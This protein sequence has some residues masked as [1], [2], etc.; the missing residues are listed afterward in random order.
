VTDPRLGIPYRVRSRKY[1]SDRPE[2]RTRNSLIKSST[3][4]SISPISG[5]LLSKV[6]Y[7]GENPSLF[8]M[9][10]MPAILVAVW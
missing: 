6:T 1:L 7:M 10:S 4:E 5:D 8:A 3:L 9:F 2:A